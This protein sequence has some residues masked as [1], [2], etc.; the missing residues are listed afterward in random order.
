VKPSPASLCFVLAAFFLCSCAASNKQAA[1]PTK[2]TQLNLPGTD[3]IL[4]DL[5]GI[6]ALPGG[7]AT[8]SFPDVGRVAGNASCNRFTGTMLVTGNSIKM[9]PLATTRMACAD[10]DIN[11]QEDIY[12][13]ALGA[14]VRYSYEAPDLLIY[15][16]GYEKPLRFM[17]SPR[18]R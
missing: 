15:A 8:L 12:L 18:D 11:R 16:E 14:A 10:N 5:A 4:T 7:K 9:G 17:R 6:P 3:W 13:K 2:N 1:S